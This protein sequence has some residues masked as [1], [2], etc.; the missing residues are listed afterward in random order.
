MIAAYL[1]EKLRPS[2]TADNI[3]VGKEFDG[4]YIVPRSVCLHSTQLVSMRVSLDWSFE[5]AFLKLNPAA[6]VVCY[7][8]TTSFS[9][10]LNE[11]L[12]DF[13]IRQYRDADRIFRHGRPPSNL[14]S[15][16]KRTFV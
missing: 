8:H 14:P 4:G 5:T 15:S 16:L 12:A 2:Q 3:R 9:R 1:P 6:E 10:A 13:C 7:D 11:G